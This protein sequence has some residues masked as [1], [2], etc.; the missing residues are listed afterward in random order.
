VTAPP[1]PAVV[2]MLSYADPGA[3]ADW[4][5]AAFGFRETF[6]LTDDDGVVVHVELAVGDGLV[7][8]G[9]PSPHYEGPRR[10]AEHCESARRWRENPYVVDGVRVLVDDV[11]AHHRRAAAAGAV[12]LSEPEDTP[13]GE[14]HYRVEDLEGHRW[15]VAQRL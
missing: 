14:R 12:I 15:M 5:V 2:P 4:L 3:A 1:L 6:R 7:M 8:L 10:H 9:C 13:Y 11:D